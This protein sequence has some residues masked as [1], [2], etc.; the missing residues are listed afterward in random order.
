MTSTPT[1]NLCQRR[2]DAK[3]EVFKHE[4]SKVKTPGLQYAYMPI[5]KIKPIVEEAYNNAGIVIDIIGLETEN[6]LEPEK[7]TTKNS[8]GE[9]STSTWFFVRGVLDLRLVNIDDPADT[10]ELSVIGE[11]KDNSD[12]VINKVY[13]AALK[14]FYKIEFNISEGPKDDTDAIQTDAD[15]EKAARQ[16]QQPK[17]AQKAPVTA[18]KA[19]EPPKDEL[20]E[21]SDTTLNNGLLKA[22]KDPMFSAMFKDALELAGVTS[23]LRLDR[24]MKIALMRKI[25]EAI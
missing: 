23:V 20:T 8:Y 11:A 7:R 24:D 14:N 12:K 3:K 4:F 16:T 1:K 2:I 10:Y 6:V 19:K 5:E 18:Q 22:S 21:I 15:L 13:T 9:E 17:V 25:E